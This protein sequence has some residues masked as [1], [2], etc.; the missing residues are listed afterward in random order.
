MKKVWTFPFPPQHCD[1][2]DVLDAVELR[3]TPRGMLCQ[4]IHEDVQ[5]GLLYDCCCPAVQT[6][7]DSLSVSAMTLGEVE[8]EDVLLDKEEVLRLGQRACDEDVTLQYCGD[9]GLDI[10]LRRLDIPTFKH[11]DGSG[12]RVHAYYAQYLL[13]YACHVHRRQ[14]SSIRPPAF[15]DLDP[16]V[17]AE[18]RKNLQLIPFFVVPRAGEAAEAYMRL[19]DFCFWQKSQ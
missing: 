14:S 4:W 5:L 6:A 10:V 17:E 12:C 15:T 11:A 1:D 18:L 2:A 8:Y 16:E 13:L 9:H 19:R 7:L 3:G